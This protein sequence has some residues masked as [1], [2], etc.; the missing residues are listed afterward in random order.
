MQHAVR[1]C[2]GRQLLV[3]SVP[4]LAKVTVTPPTANNEPTKNGTPATGAV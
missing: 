3:S 4:R 1:Q 2:P